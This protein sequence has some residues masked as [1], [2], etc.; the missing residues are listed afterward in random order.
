MPQKN[1]FRPG[2]GQAPMY[3]AGRENEAKKFEKLLDQN[4]VLKNIILIGLRGV[5]KTALLKNLKSKA[6]K[7]RWLWSGNDFDE[8]INLSEEKICKRL[9]A[10][11]AVLLQPLSTRIEKKYAIGFLTKPQK[12]KV[13]IS[14]NDLWN[15]FEVTP[16]LNGDKI[17]AVLRNVRN[18]LVGTEIKG[19]VFAYD[20]AHSLSGHTKSEEF[21]LSLL[22]DTFASLQQDN[23]EI[24]ILLVM[25][26]LPILLP[27]LNE[28][29]T[30]SERMF[31]IFRLEQLSDKD[32]EQA[33]KKPMELA[34]SKITF[35]QEVVNSIVKMS[36]GYPYFIQ[37][38]C[39]ETFDS[40][41]SQIGS[42]I[43]SHINE[44]DILE[45]LDQGFFAA[46]WES[47]TDRQQEFMSV[48][49]KLDTNDGEFTTH[50]VV[51]GSKKYLAKG[52]S[53]SHATQMLGHLF[54]EGLVYRK[55]HGKY[56]FAVPF[57]SEFIKRQESD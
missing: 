2:A 56:C 49:A 12:K 29:R 6:D 34:K 51:E 9:V 27:Q 28:T 32:S 15:I 5:G 48:I 43:A 39:K 54:K 24:Q 37:Y 45:K 21:P 7:K 14:F 38:I 4:P 31:D 18:I 10:D 23:H 13:S 20:E 50:Q 47:A 17:K 11:L 19:I 22:L 44:A 26:G 8:S 30:F 55:K 41:I 25:T 53:A 36:G 46:R 16:G 35:S 40:W 33:I 57:M 52:F 42:G 3:L 1:P